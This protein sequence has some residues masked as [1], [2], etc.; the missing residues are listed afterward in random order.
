MTKKQGLRLVVFIVLLGIVLNA[1]IGVFG[2]PP[3][4]G[5]ISIKKRFGEFYSG[6]ENTWDCVMVGASCVDREWV[7]PLAWNDYGMAVYPMNTARQPLVLT[8]NILE[9]VREKQDVKLA[10][11]DIRGIQMFTL[12]PEEA[13][14]RNLLDNMKN[15]KNRYQAVKKIIKFYK[16]YFSREDVKDGQEMLEKLDEASLY[17]PFIKYH[18]RW[19]TGLYDSDFEGITSD[20]KGVYEEQAFVVKEVE[21]TKMVDETMELNELQKSILDEIVNYGKD[22]GLE[23]LFITSPT[24]LSKREVIET[25]AAVRY[26]EEQGEKVI[27]YNTEEKYQEIGIDFSKDLYNEHHLN[28]RGAVKFTN[29]FAKYLHD[30]YQFE[31]KRGKDEYKDWDDAYV[32]YLE[33]YEKGWKDAEKEK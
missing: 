16:E 32:R 24:H 27:D 2:F 8:T 19:K 14:I 6:A 3:N 10:V 17:L 22:T 30:N 28:S 20:M 12:R 26:L 33:F 4:D 9:E 31:D 18:S 25:K 13:K 11:V 15:S 1:M 5:T 23:I 7:A 29:Y 21:P